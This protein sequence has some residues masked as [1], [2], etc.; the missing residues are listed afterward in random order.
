VL[1]HRIQLSADAEIEGQTPETALAR[2]LDQ[3]EAPRQ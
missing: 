1:R 3:V 2:L